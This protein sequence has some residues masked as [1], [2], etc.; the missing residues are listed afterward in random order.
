[1]LYKLDEDGEVA[2]CD[3]KTDGDPFQD[4]RRMIAKHTFRIRPH[5]WRPWK[6]VSIQVSTVFL[7]VDHAFGEDEPVLWE[8]MLFT[9]FDPLENSCWRY[10]SRQ[11]ALAGHHAI[12]AR[13]ER[14]EISR[15]DEV[16]PF[17]DPVM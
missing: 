15:V 8:T 4:E 17:V 5:R 11:K 16:G 7:C 13:L 12:C 2:I 9:R 14:N 10:T 3:V 1:M 6:R